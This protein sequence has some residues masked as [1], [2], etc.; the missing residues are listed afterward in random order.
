[1]TI[2]V[3]KKEE[4]KTYVSDVVGKKPSEAISIKKYQVE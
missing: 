3:K 2:L 4:K 1:M